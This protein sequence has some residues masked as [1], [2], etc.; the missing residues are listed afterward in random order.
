MIDDIVVGFEDA[1]RE[2]VV[3]HVLPDVFD[4]I[5]FRR[6]GRKLGGVDASLEAV[7]VLTDEAA[8]MDHGSIPDDQQFA[9]QLSLQVFQE[10]DDLRTF[11]RARM[12]LE[13]E[14]P[15]GD[16]ADDR[17]LLPVEVELQDRGLAFGT[18][19]AYPVWLLAQAAFVD[20]D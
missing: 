19:C 2:P 16:A 4:G 14:V 6:I 3:A 1:V 10:L 12:E 5:E 18:P 13:V 9:G 11:D 7:E 17:E 20:E 8:A 15:N